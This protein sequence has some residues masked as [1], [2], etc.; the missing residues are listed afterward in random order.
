MLKFIDDIAGSL[1]DVMKFLI[2]SLCYFLA[3]VLIVAIPL[4]VIVFVLQAFGK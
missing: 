2:R 4:Y 1:Y 3:G